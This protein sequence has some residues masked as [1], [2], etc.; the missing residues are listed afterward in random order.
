MSR[1]RL[2]LLALLAVFA[3]SAIASATA[4]AEMVWI[5][6]SI[7]LKKGERFEAESQGGPFVMKGRLAGIKMEVKCESE[8]DLKG[9]KKEG[10]VENPGGGGNAIGFDKWKF[11]GCT[12]GASKPKTVE[13][14]EVPGGGQINAEVNLGPVLK[15]GVVF[16]EFKP[17]AG[18]L[19]WVITFVNCKTA[20]LNGEY[21]ATGILNAE[22]K[23]GDEEGT[24]KF[25][26]GELELIFG[27]GEATFEGEMKL[28]F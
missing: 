8:S 14:C 4:S 22:S 3:L 1:M 18:N 20:A 24:D 2:L 23:N 15:G 11:S 12:I 6:E 25:K 10:W 19:L 21:E 9:E 7:E 5:K 17:I 26:T 28:K 13:G 27:G 16:V